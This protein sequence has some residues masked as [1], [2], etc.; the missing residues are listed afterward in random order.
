MIRKS[1]THLMISAAMM[2][3]W[4]GCLDTSSLEQRLDSLEQKLAGMYTAAQQ[5]NSN[6]VALRAFYDEKTIIT[7]Y[8]RTESGYSLQLSDGTSVNVYFG[9]QVQGIVPLIAIDG[10]GNWIMSIDGGRTF[11][12]IEGS[13]NAFEGM[14]VNPIVMVDE[15]G[16]WLLSLDGGQS[17]DYVRDAKGRP[18]SAVDGSDLSGL[19]SI[20]KDV[21][22][23][24]E[25][26]VIIFTLA[27][28]ETVK[29][30]YVDSFYLN[31][32]GWQQGRP[33]RSGAHLTY[34]VECSQIA[35]CMIQAP[36]GWDVTLT[37]EMLS[38]YAPVFADEHK[39]TVSIYLTSTKG[40]LRRMDLEFTTDPRSASDIGCKI[41]QDFANDT[42]ENILLDYS[43]AGYMNGEVAPPD[44]WS[45]GY[46]VYNV[47]DYGAVPDDGKS[48]RDAFLAA[49]DA[50]LGGREYMTSA[51]AVIY[52]P[53]G[54][55]ILHSSDDNSGGKT[56]SLY[57][58][59]GDFVIK[60][61]GADKTTITM[62]DPALPNDIQDLYS[63][64]MMIEV[65]HFSGLSDLAVIAA[66]SPKGSFSVTCASAPALSKGDY[67]CLCVE[68]KSA[69]FIAQELYP[70]TMES[71]MTE[72]AGEGVKVYDYHKVVA[73]S[74]N[75]VT[76]AEPLMH[77]VE[78]SRGWKLCNYPHYANV[79]VEDICFK[80]DAKADFV[81]HGSWQ[82]DGAYK[83]I[84]FT[85]LTDSWLRRCRFESV[86]EAFTAT[87]C[88]NISVYDVQIEGNRGHSSVRSQG[89]S[90]VLIAAV[91][92]KSGQG[93]GQYH[94]AGVSKTT[95]GTVLWR[96][97]WG[98]D[99]CFES[100]A[101]QPR[102]TL[103]DCCRGGWKQSHQGGDASQVPNHLN[104]LTI[105]N[106][107]STTTYSGTWNWYN[108]GSRN[109][110]FVMPIIVGFHGASCNMN[111]GQCL[112]DFSHGTAVE[113]ES[114][115]EEQLALRMGFVPAWLNMLKYKN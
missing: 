53:E 1:I 98:D 78:A 75:R 111:A 26:G 13:A 102:A 108:S 72:L 41:W 62:K 15:Q 59:A 5:A 22:V 61:A 2:L 86:S 10:Q 64:P 80:G 8:E 70:Y 71:G 96:C 49:Y 66:D 60:G 14:G 48:D 16:Y 50:A 47:M 65:K 63:S 77:A 82:D 56:R 17:W 105:W 21:Q 30:A 19:N 83:P 12:P 58:R 31:I 84:G 94:G 68:N 23:D 25:Q 39:E 54:E 55:F 74:G 18:V 106:M 7:A 3:C 107:E 6:V 109:W 9:S 37:D 20:F 27:G 44:V 112:V 45:L 95:M 36:Q 52:F 38:I 101:G 35:S 103:I 115:Y 42:P 76:F 90:R 34:T 46:K 79:G 24:A 73:V 99:S 88:A 85:R 4:T 67:V 11:T 40:L 33:I 51:R 97:S 114:L 81:H 110:K 89:S 93:K 113:P 104:D 43:Y 92:D 91:N 57:V 69:D 29:V 87:S 28:G 100:H 32:L